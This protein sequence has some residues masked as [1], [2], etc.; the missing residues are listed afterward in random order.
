[1]THGASHADL[2]LSAALFIG[3]IYKVGHN[4]P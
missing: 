1:M 3:A 2:A 4:G